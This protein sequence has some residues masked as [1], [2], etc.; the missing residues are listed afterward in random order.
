MDLAVSRSIPLGGGRNVQFRVD[1]FNAFNSVIYNAVQ[2]TEQLIKQPRRADDG[3]KQPVQCRWHVERC[4]SAA[5]ERRIWRGDWCAG[6]ADCA[7]SVEIPVLTGSAG[8]GRARRMHM[9]AWPSPG[10]ALIRHAGQAVAVTVRRADELRVMMI[11]FDF[12]PQPRNGEVDCSRADVGVQI[13][14]HRTE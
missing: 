4:A 11:D 8:R 12:A 10:G 7:A 5:G 9:S 14:P 2:F 6:D 3:D 13:S 1:L